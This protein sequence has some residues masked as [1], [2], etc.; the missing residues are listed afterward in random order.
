MRHAVGSI[1]ANQGGPV[2]SVF[3]R[4]GNLVEHVSRTGGAAACGIHVEEGVEKVSVWRGGGSAC[5]ND[6]VEFLA[7]GEGGLSRACS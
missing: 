2:D 3:V 5:K 4:I 7:S 1:A 6:G